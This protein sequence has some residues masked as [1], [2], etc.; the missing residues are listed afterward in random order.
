MHVAHMAAHECIQQQKVGHGNAAGG[1]CQP[2]VSPAQAK[3][4][5]PV[6]EEIH[7]HGDEAHDHRRL[8]PVES[9]ERRHEHLHRRI[10]GEPDRIEAQGGGRLLGLIGIEPAVLVENRDD[11]L[12]EDDQA[13]GC[14][15]GEQKGEPQAT[16]K[17]AAEVDAVAGGDQ[18]RQHRQRHR[19]QGDAKDPERQLHEAKGDCEPENRSVA[20]GRCKHGVDHDVQLH[21]ACSD[22]RGAH[23]PQDLPDARI[24]P[25]K[26]RPIDVAEPCE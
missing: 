23:E 12:G 2:A 8:A 20:Q 7:S 6:E 24:T 9:V 4:E 16:G 18:T 15:Y 10:G 13:D 22:D 5:Q 21:G 3:R 1:Q 19:R 26:I 25:A 11:G 14:G 17:L